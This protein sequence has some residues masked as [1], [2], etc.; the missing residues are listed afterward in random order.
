M[1]HSH[2]QMNS[3]KLTIPTKYGRVSYSQDD[4][5]CESLKL[6]GEWAEVQV[7]LFQE[8]LQPGDV[9]LEFGVRVGTSTLALARSVATEG[10]VHAYEFAGAAL[11]ALSST[12]VENGTANVVV[13]E[14]DERFRRSFAP[15]LPVATDVAPTNTIGHTAIDNVALIKLDV[16]RVDSRLLADLYQL[17]SQHKPL[18]F[19]SFESLEE[20]YSAFSEIQ[21]PTYRAYFVATHA[22]NRDN[23]SKAADNIFGSSMDCGMLFCPSDFVFEDANS[24]TGAIKVLALE[25]FEDLA[26]A[27]LSVPRHGDRTPFDRAPKI[28]RDELARLRFQVAEANV[29]FDEASSGLAHAGTALTTNADLRSRLKKSDAKL[30]A[31]KKKLKAHEALIHDL[32]NSTSWKFARPVRAARKAVAALRLR[33][34]GLFHR[35]AATEV[36]LPA[37]KPK[38]AAHRQEQS[39]TYLDQEVNGI[40]EDTDNTPRKVEVPAP[41]SREAW[42]RLAREFERRSPQTPTLDIVVPVYG[43]ARETL[44]CLFHVL[45]APQRT[46]YDL[47]VIDDCGPDPELSLELEK[48]ASRGLISLLKNEVNLGFVASVNRGMALHSDRDVLLLN[49]DTAV[50]G[51]WLDRIVEFAG[52]NAKIG[53]VT[54][55]SNNATICSYPKFV[56]DNDDMLEL[57]DATLDQIAARVNAGKSVEIPTAVGFCMYISRACLDEV[58]LFDVANFGRGYGEENDFCRR[59]VK[60]GWSNVLVGN[61]FVRHYGGVSFKESKRALVQEAEKRMQ[62][63]HPEYFPTVREFI[64]NDPVLEIRENLDFERLRRHSQAKGPAM[65]FITL[66]R[67]GGTE[68]H[69]QEMQQALRTEG[70]SVFTLRSDPRQP[71]SL[72]F[73]NQD[74][75]DV[76]NLPNLS[77]PYDPKTL[78]RII[79]RLNIKHIHVQ[80]LADAGDGAEHMIREAAHRAGILYDVTVHDYM[81]VCPRITLTSHSGVYCGEPEAAMCNVCISTLP[82][83]AGDVTI[84][85]WR[86]NFR[87]FLAEARS[88]FVPSDDAANRMSRYF[89]HVVFTVRPHFTAL[90]PRPPRPIPNRRERHIAIIGA[91]GPQKGSGLL[92][93]C[94]RYALKHQIPIRFIIVGYASADQE[95]RG[96]PNVTITGRY[97]E[98]E[99]QNVLDEQAP[100]IVWLPS[101][102]PETFSY[103]LSAALEAGIFPVVFDLGAPAERLRALRWGGIMPTEYMLSVPDILSF[104]TSVEIK[105]PP[106]D[107]AT[108]AN[109]TYGSV[110]QEYYKLDVAG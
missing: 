73:D 93:E 12:V 32:Y 31:Y 39:I 49:S 51:N 61:V 27:F 19:V 2:E 9:V 96:L 108:A 13:N 84:E 44:N 76:P 94:A 59:A 77:T 24:A 5:V 14:L 28:W 56:S 53:T 10:T 23:V 33:T 85:K 81:Y 3:L 22:F 90:K 70:V 45:N 110:L 86:A 47:V 89:P 4:L 92:V 105:G 29:R 57:D 15:S 38:N 98:S 101:V 64:R 107:I 65:L 40:T 34:T 11:D 102:L 48:L 8:L 21:R 75:R 80:H 43:Q 50:Y 97:D 63:L 100:D 62:A 46:A 66:G 1:K 35:Q 83:I 41:P 88:V 17:I 68:R 30:K 104:L 82:S 109:V 103:T 54:P 72:R 60:K 91:I 71:G 67:G 16:T 99:L 7:R 55:L 106:K 87:V 42:E 25:S 74:L 79:D 58:G 78:I 36:S 6:Y 95:L 26:T 37:S 20:A 52:S 69:V 18:I